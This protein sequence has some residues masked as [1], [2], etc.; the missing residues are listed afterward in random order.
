MV[1]NR[2]LLLSGGTVA[3]VIVLNCFC[4]LIFR[5]RFFTSEAVNLTATTAFSD[6]PAFLASLVAGLPLMSQI[7]LF[8]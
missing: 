2:R 4:C 7:V 5:T 6:P 8:L 1:K 3:G